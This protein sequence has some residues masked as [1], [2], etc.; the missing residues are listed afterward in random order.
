MNWNAEGYLPHTEERVKHLQKVIAGRP[1]AIIVPGPSI[2]ELEHR[3]EE[4]RDIDICYFGLNSYTVI[5]THI[6]QQINKQFSAIMCSSREG[7]PGILEDIIDFLDRDEDNMFISSFWRGT[8]DLLPKY[9]DLQYL[10]DKH[11]KKFIFFSLGFVTTVPDKEHPLHFIV[12][13]SLLVLM[14]MAIVGKTQSIV[15]FGADGGFS[16]DPDEWF[17]RQD[18]PGYRS[19][20]NGGLIRTPK[21]AIIAH[22]NDYCNTIAPIT[23]PNLYEAY[24]FAPT[25][26]LNCSENSLYTPFTKVSYDTA[27]EYLGV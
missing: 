26:I 7:I 18:D 16:K 2:R 13:N 14:Q 19:S 10:F 17:Y 8:F 25:A 4:L 23:L 20:F 21:D 5:E 3:V 27:F 22:T 11:N 15:L 12:S 9:F 1:V 6:L 24:G